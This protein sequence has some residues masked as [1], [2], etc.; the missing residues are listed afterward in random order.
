MN[1]IRL[2]N[3]VNDYH[4][5]KNEFRSLQTVVAQPYFNA[6]TYPDVIQQLSSLSEWLTAEA[7]ALWEMGINVY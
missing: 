7:D 5:K 1:E 3:R 6:T 4:I 2:S